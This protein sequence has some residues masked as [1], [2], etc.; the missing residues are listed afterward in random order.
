MS[1]QHSR[2]DL[3]VPPQGSNLRFALT[4]AACASAGFGLVWGGLGLRGW[5]RRGD[6][7]PAASVEPGTGD[8]KGFYAGQDYLKSQINWALR[9]ASV[10][11][12][13]KPFA[14][15]AAV[16]DGFSIKDTFDG[17][18]PYYFP[19]GSRVVKIGRAHV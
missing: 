11:S 1:D 9:G 12:T 14:M 18:S 10:G 4:A 6:A 19:D 2:Q 15:A 17:N 3:V 8:L 13:F 5:M 16:K 7:P